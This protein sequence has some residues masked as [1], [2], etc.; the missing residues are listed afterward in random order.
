MKYDVCA[1][2]ANSRLTHSSHERLSRLCAVGPLLRSLWD[3]D[4][5][6]VEV[7]VGSCNV[8]VPQPERSQSQSP[9]SL[10]RSTGLRAP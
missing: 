2:H 8:E 6:V 7:A 4:N 9:L 10:S 1:L 3:Q 5:V